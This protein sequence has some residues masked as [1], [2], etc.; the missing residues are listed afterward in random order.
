[1]QRAIAEIAQS[2]RD[3]DGV[4]CFAWSLIFSGVLAIAAGFGLLAWRAV[5]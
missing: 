3:L 4:E 2:W 1:M 5:R